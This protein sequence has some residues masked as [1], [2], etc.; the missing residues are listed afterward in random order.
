MKSVK[1]R[2]RSGCRRRKVK[3]DEVKPACSGCRKS[4]IK[5]LWPNNEKQSLSHG[6]QFHIE[7]LPQTKRFQFVMYRGD[8][9]KEVPEQPEQ[10][11]EPEQVVDPAV[12]DSLEELVPFESVVSPSLDVPLD[13]EYSNAVYSM[14][15]SNALVAW[16]TS[17]ST[18]NESPLLFQ[19]FLE[20]FLNSVSPQPCHPRLSPQANFVPLAMSNPTMMDIFNACGASFLSRTDPSMRVEAKRRYSL[21]LTN[22]ANSLSKAQEGAEEWMAAAVI[23]LCLRDKFSGTSPIVPASHLAKALEMIRQL[24]KK[25]KSSVIS[26]KFLVESFLFN[27]TVMLLT[28]TQEVVQRLP[29]PFEVYDEWR[30][31]LDCTPFHTALPFMKYPVFGAARQVYEIAAKVSWLYSR[32][33]LSALDK[34]VACDLLRQT[35]TTELPEISSSAK[36]ELLPSELVHLQESI[37]L[38]D[39]I[40]SC[41]ILLLH[42]L[43]FPRLEKN[44]PSVQEIVGNIINRL[45]ALT[46]ESPIWIICAWPLLVCGMATSAVSHQH[47]IYSQCQ[48]CASR[49][50]MEFLDQ[51]GKFLVSV[52][53][54]E[55][56][57]GMG[58]D[59]LFNRDIISRVYL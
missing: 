33:P 51:I 12:V 26:L 6:E 36:T 11:E 49:F 43:L 31:I 28:G 18:D 10:P 13:R 27:Y 37:Y 19:A 1:K 41:C 56:E 52:W 34:A 9:D 2:T 45:Y 57:P 14:A 59:C 53:G 44:D 48:R 32:L 25:G 40:R 42:K 4:N 58:W 29:S 3:C 15:P 55:N 54:T 21:C 24:R 39:I 17:L 8:Q 47:F 5:C 46:A 7:R 23:L 22:F 16:G 50:Q 30:T 20:G 38:A 35:Y